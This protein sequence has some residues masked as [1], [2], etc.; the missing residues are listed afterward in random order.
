[1]AIPPIRF[2]SV[3]RFID[4]LEHAIRHF[5]FF[6]FV[7]FGD[8]DFLLRDGKQLEDF[9]GQYRKKIGLP[10]AICVS[11]NTFRSEK[12]EI[13]LDAGLKLVQLGVQ[14]GSQ[15]ILD[16]VFDRKIKVTKTKE[17]VRQ[18]EPYYKT[19]G[20]ILLLDFIIDNPYETRNDIIQTYRYLTSLPP[21]VRVN[22]FC[23][24]FFPGTPIYNKALKDGFIEHYD[25]K[26]SRFFDKAN[27]ITHQKNY[28]TFLI[29]LFRHP[30]LRR[31][32]PRFI[33]RALGSRLA[34][35]IASIFPQS[36]YKMLI[37]NIKYLT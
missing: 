37:K 15:R 2:Q 33:L 29:L 17:V 7:V 31:H 16:E 28:E 1:M 27:I 3:N 24:A 4:E 34:R 36:F 10:F 20:M 6:Q 5:D 9:A 35:G 8:D 12:M 26:T 21:H 22:I 13:L 30:R 18:I 14:S 23:L 19:H 32:T 25:E 11:A